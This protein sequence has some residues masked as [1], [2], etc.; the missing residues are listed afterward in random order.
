MSLIWNLLSRLTECSK[1]N[2]QARQH[3]YLAQSTDLTELE[4]RMR[5]LDRRQQ[6]Q[7]HWMG[8]TAA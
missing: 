4:R 1:R 2:H 7:P 3:A 8:G 6:L 5:E